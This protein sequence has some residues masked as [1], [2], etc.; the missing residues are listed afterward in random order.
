MSNVHICNVMS[1]VHIYYLKVT[2]VSRDVV[3][4]TNNIGHFLIN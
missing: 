1:N 2:F 3:E 4:N